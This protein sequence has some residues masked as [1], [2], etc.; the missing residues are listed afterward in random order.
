MGYGY[1]L[2]ACPQL[3]SVST[4]SPRTAYLNEV[5]RKDQVTT[6]KIVTTKRGNHWAQGAHVTAETAALIDK[7][8]QK[9]KNDT[10]WKKE[11]HI[12]ARKKS[13]KSQN[14]K[15]HNQYKECKSAWYLKES[16]T[17]Q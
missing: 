15:N 6:R 17:T 2:F 4:S 3:S 10:F 14:K 11:R 12:E 1:N 8:H 5:R 9:V 16:I 13:T 7:D